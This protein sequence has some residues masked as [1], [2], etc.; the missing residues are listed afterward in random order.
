[1]PTKPETPSRPIAGMMDVEFIGRR[2]G[3]VETIVPRP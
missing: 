3:G 2:F 1:M